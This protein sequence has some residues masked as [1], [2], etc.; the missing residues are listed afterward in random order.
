MPWISKQS[1]HNKFHFWGE[2]YTKHGRGLHV[3]NWLYQSM[4]QTKDIHSNKSDTLL[5]STD[6]NMGD[7]EY[8][9]NICFGKSQQLWSCKI[10]VAQGLLVLKRCGSWDSPDA[11]T[12]WEQLLWTIG[13][14]HRQHGIWVPQPH[15]NRHNSTQ[16]SW[17]GFTNKLPYFGED[18]TESWLVF[19]L[20]PQIWIVAGLPC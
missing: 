1:I 6:G 3:Q 17:C 12:T 4:L 10:G 15:W 5:K 20:N 13:V 16:W 19:M 8:S 9:I 11:M 2:T 7:H 18:I 14:F